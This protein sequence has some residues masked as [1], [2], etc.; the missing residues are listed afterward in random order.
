MLSNEEFGATH[1]DKIQPNVIYEDDYL[2]A[3]DKPSGMLVHPSPIDRKETWVATQWIEVHLGWKPYSVHRLDKATSGLLLFAKSAEVAQQMGDIFEN[4]QVV[5]RYHAIVR[6]H[7]ESSGCID[8]ALKVK[9]PFRSEQLLAD[10]KPAQSAVTDYKLLQ[11][12]ELD[13]PVDRYPVARYSLVEVIPKTGRKHQ[14]RRHF[15]HIYHPL[16]GDTSYGKSSHNRFFIS[17]FNIQRLLLAAIA[18]EFEHPV[19]GVELKLKC[20]LAEEL[21][22]L[23]GELG[24][25][26]YIV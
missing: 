26:D 7:V 14:I 23:Y 24:L 8:Y 5:K 25:S 10:L 13:K 17:H 12:I 4:R 18:L 21:K 15:K 20:E 9:S 11:S 1:S 3:L 2:L 6:G 22:Q 16:V 19:H